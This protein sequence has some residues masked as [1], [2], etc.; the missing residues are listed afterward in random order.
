MA[1]HPTPDVD[2]KNLETAHEMWTAFTKSGKY[3]VILTCVILVGLA[4]AFVKF[5]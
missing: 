3:A 2:P 4:L 5:S 1:H